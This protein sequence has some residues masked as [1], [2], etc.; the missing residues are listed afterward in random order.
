MNKLKNYWKIPEKSIEI[1]E[2]EREQLLYVLKNKFI[3]RH[4]KK[5]G[6]NA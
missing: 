3:N 1:E 6:T 4:H 5:N 2:E